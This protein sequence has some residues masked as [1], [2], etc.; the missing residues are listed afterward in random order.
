[1]DLMSVALAVE[2]MLLPYTHFAT[3]SDSN[4]LLRALSLQRYY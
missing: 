1:M 2:T 3:T 4:F